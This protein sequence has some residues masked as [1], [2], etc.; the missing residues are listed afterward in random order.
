M[1]VIL[2]QKL[3]TLQTSN[4]AIKQIKGRTIFSDKQ[5]SR[6]QSFLDGFYAAENQN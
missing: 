4:F 5:K 3:K 2:I 6:K 1:Y